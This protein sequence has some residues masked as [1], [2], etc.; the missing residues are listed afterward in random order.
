MKPVPERS[1][2]RKGAKKNPPAAGGGRRPVWTGTLAFGL[3]TLPVE[4]HSTVRRSSGSLRMIGP[5]G[6]PLKRHYYSEQ[7]GKL[8]AQDDIVRGYELDDGS[9]VLIEDEEL[10][11]LDPEHSRT[12][13]LD[14]FVPVGQLDPLLVDNTYLLVPLRDALP[15]YRL[16]VASMADSGRAGIARFVLRER[17][18]QLA[19]VSAGG[20]LRALTLRYP[21]EIRTA[22][23]VG[24]PEPDAAD[25]DAIEKLEAAMKKLTVQEL[26]TDVLVDVEAQELEK[27]VKKK[28]KKSEDV[29]EF[30]GDEADDDDDE[31]EV[32]DVMALLKASLEAGTA[33][34]T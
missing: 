32:A 14:V 5:D 29:H 20:T 34:G 18:Y 24:L 21:D 2:R 8:L 25:I 3:V 7:S 11:E 16:L 28:L 17:A 6:T 19:I 33:A 22:Q 31:E 26:E 12:I 10:D 27:L 9:F 30:K 15:A 1:K 4:L 13:D 23:D